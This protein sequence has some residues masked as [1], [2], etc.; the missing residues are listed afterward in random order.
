MSEPEPA[1]VS[2][3]STGKFASITQENICFFVN[4]E[5]VTYVQ[6]E[7]CVEYCNKCLY[8]PA[9]NFPMSLTCGVSLWKREL[10]RDT[11]TIC[12]LLEYYRKHL[13][14]KAIL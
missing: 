14:Q 4:L 1:L 12:F 5:S 3:N 6:K 7:T 2:L 10:T 11:T 9:W 8:P 13:F